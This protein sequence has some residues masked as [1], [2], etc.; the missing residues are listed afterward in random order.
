MRNILNDLIESELDSLA[1]QTKK[2]TRTHD[3]K[4]FA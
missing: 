4:K 2:S 1:K 3:L